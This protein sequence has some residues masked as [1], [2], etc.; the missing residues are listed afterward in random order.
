MNSP[1]PWKAL[2]GKAP[3]VLPQDR[4]YIEAFNAERNRNEANRVRT[5]LIPEPFFGRRDAPVVMLLLNPGASPRT[6]AFHGDPAFRRRLLADMRGMKVRKHFH[7]T[8]PEHG[9]GRRWWERTCASL[10]RCVSQDVV[11]NNLLAVEF[12]AYPSR[13]FNHGHLRLPSQAFTFEL[14]RRAI[15]RGEI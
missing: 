2:P 13:S 1:F 10:I 3:F 5:D 12:F 4:P 9:P 7:L 11:A 15:D 6:D 14:V 8:D